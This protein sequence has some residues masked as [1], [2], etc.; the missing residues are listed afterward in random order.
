MTEPSTAW[1]RRLVFVAAI[2]GL[3]LAIYCLPL[4]WHAAEGT[5]RERLYDTITSVSC[6]A[7]FSICLL[8]AWR[9]GDSVANLAIAL[10]LTAAFFND[11]VA[12]YFIWTGLEHT[13]VEQIGNK[14]TYIAGAGLFLRASQQFPQALTARQ[15]KNVALVVLLRPA[16]LW[17]VTIALSLTATLSSGTLLATAARLCIIGLG[18]TF[19]YKSYRTGDADTRRKVLWFLAMAIGAAVLT[20]VTAAA[21]LAMGENPPE[22]LRLVVGVSLFALSSVVIFGCVAAAVFYAGAITP[23]LVIRKTVVYGLTTSLLLFVFATVEVFLHHE[24]VHLLHVTDTFASSM[25][26]G[27]FG[28]TFHPVKHYFEHLLERFHVRHG[29]K[30]AHHAELGDTSSHG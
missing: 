27:A 19:F 29:M 1:Q 2:A 6:I 30:P 21:K 20:V 10:A 23:T 16:V 13:L 3:A 9:G 11:A 12:V 4:I 22:A 18:I 14:V 8:I 7:M 25:I 28:L 26:G 5:L 17:A 15:V 24:L